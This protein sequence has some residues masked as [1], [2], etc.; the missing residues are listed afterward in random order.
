MHS[1]GVLSTY[2]GVP[3]GDSAYKALTL[4]TRHV[5]AMVSGEPINI[6]KTSCM[7]S[8]HNEVSLKFELVIEVLVP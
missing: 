8:D 7:N 3:H 2:V 4:R 6:N 1:E 5:L